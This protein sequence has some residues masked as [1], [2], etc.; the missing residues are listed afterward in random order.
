[1]W[2]TPAVAVAAATAATAAA[3]AAAAACGVKNH[4]TNSYQHVY[5]LEPWIGPSSLP[6][7]SAQRRESRRG[8]W[9]TP[10]VAATVPAATAAAAACVR[11][12]SQ[13]E[14]IPARICS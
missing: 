12:N 7:P 1:M 10:A 2:E 9:E 3:A 13:H 8:M 6:V 5:V 14:F 4:N 11:E